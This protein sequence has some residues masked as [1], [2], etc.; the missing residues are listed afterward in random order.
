MPN[1]QLSYF[2]GVLLTHKHNLKYVPKT[3]TGQNFRE[4]SHSISQNF[5]RMMIYEW[6][7]SEYRQ[8]LKK[9]MIGSALF[10][11]VLE[12]VILLTQAQALGWQMCAMLAMPR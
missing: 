7:L 5:G 12:L 9:K 6:S 8:N 1:I 3:S 10:L 2:N 4:I 11:S